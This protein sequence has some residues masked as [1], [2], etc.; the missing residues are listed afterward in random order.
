VG[1]LFFAVCLCFEIWFA[2][3]VVVVAACCVFNLVAG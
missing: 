3:S 2:D 1:V